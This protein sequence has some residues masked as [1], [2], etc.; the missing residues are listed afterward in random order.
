MPEWHILDQVLATTVHSWSMKNWTLLGWNTEILLRNIWF[1]AIFRLKKE[2]IPMSRTFTCLE[3]GKTLPRNPRLKKQKYCSCLACQNARRYTTN[4]SRVKKSSDSRR[5]C[6]ARN[7]RWRDAY[8]AH[9]YQKR[10]RLDHPG[11]VKRNRDLQRERNRKYRKDQ[12]PIIVKTYTLS[13]QPLRDGA[14]AGFEV[15]SGKIVKTY[16]LMA[17]HQALSDLGALYPPNPG[18]L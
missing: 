6:Q 8:P 16:A 4:K 9:E 10:Y 15:K 3:C 12:V 2:Q 17:Q 1:S 7:K 18:W 14:Y 5:L 13:P 11:Y